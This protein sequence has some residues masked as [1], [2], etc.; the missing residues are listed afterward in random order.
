MDL[1]RLSL[2]DKHSFKRITISPE[3]IKIHRMVN[4]VHGCL[5]AVLP[6][7]SIVGFINVI[8]RF[9]VVSYP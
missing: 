9:I 6:E 5:T 8:F 2:W 3:S 7:F 1:Y 4:T